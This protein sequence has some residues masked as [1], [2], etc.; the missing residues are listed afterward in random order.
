MT[1]EIEYRPDERLVVLHDKDSEIANKRRVRLQLD[2]TFS[3]TTKPSGE[4][5][6]NVP[7]GEE[8]K[9]I[10]EA[11]ELLEFLSIGSSIENNAQEVVT[12]Y[13]EDENSFK[14]FSQTAHRIWL[15]ELEPP[16]L[17]E[18]TK[19]LSNAWPKRELYPLQLLASFHL[20]FSQN[21]C[22]FSV[23]GAGKTSTVLGAYTY[24]TSLP[25]KHPK[26]VNRILVVGPLSCFRPWED[27]FKACFARDSN[28]FRISGEAN[29]TDI[30]RVLRSL[31]DEIYQI[32]MLLITYQSLANNLEAVISLI[33]REEN[34]F[35][36]VL[37][38]AHRAKRTDGGLWASSA[39]ALAPY[40]KA[41]VVLTGTP[42]PNGFQD[43]YNLFEFIWP[44]RNV[45]GYSPGHLRAM[46]S[47]PYDSRRSVVTN[48][49]A[50]FF[51]R[52]SKADLGLDPP[53]ENDSICIEMGKIQREIYDYIERAYIDYFMKDQEHPLNTF[54]K[55]RQI[56]LLQ[57]ATNPGLLTKPISDNFDYE[58][59]NALY[60]DDVELFESII[61]YSE[62]EIP[63][64]F[65]AAL[66][67]INQFLLKG[68][69]V[70]VWSYYIGNILGFQGFLEKNSIPSKVLYGAIEPS[71]ND[72]AVETRETII[73]HFHEKDSDFRV[74]I[75]N[76]Y[77]VGESISLHQACR[78]AIYIERNF[79]AAV[80]L[81]SKDRIH[82]YGMPSGCTSTYNYL[83]S[84]E[85]VEETV[86]RR[87]N[88]KVSLMMEVVESR[89]IPLLD[90]T[91][92]SQDTEQADILAIISDYRARK[93]V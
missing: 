90:L 6:V 88:E 33:G 82:R 24:L 13:L 18:F 16:E 85:S 17:L 36:V 60:V 46:T 8:E 29:K 65:F 67:L 70:I 7:N 74:I 87:L 44:R 57:A 92:D 22:N 62:S 37:D 9:I 14:E 73:S 69:K 75:A 5:W 51:I 53:I 39:I 2:Q 10:R 89:E 45:I 34:R 76:P 38:E 21:A 30:E 4:Y 50:P 56:R 63:V 1:V 23:P 32:E 40:A 35:M 49:I 48:N 64:K 72:P 43:L 79:N 52:I 3:G 54:I 81:Q 41:R 42:A 15:G 25:T 26:N 28:S 80:F 66:E 20:A 83:V 68:E 11:I 71:S 12:G 31:S 78:N 77:A 61:S 93:F 91:R 59:S 55:S 84:T 86:E 27:E 19:S 47:N 58:L